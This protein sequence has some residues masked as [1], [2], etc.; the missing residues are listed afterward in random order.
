M[1]HDQCTS[2][3]TGIYRGAMLETAECPCSQWPCALSP[4]ATSGNRGLSSEPTTLR[5]TT[6]RHLTTSG[7]INI[8]ASQL[9]KSKLT[10]YRLQPNNN[11]EFISLNQLILML[12]N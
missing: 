8:H 1:T 5:P 12:T 9:T 6:N 2:R 4:R 11:P 10:S 7:Y 3:S